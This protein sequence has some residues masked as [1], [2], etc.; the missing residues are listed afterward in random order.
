MSTRWR[1]SPFIQLCFALHAVALVALVLAPTYWLAVLIFLLLLHGV[2]ATVGLWP[3]SDWLGANIRR[4]PAA[5]AARGAIAITIDDGPDPEVT[6]QVLEI[7]RERGA[8]ATFFC[9]GERAQAHPALCRAIVSAGCAVENHGQRH[10]KHTATFGPRGWRDEVAQAQATLEVICGQRPRFFR[11][12]AGLR[13]PL[14]DPLLQRLGLQLVSWT[15]RGY[16]TRRLNPDRVLA[17]LLRDLAPGD[18]LLLHD[19]NAARAAGRPLILDVL[20]RLLDALAARNLTT[21]TLR[22]VLP[23]AAPNADATA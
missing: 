3:R 9:I 21:V 4:L 23:A 5:V 8:N 2:I 6:P 13:N 11:P 18:I 1:P 15:R 16:D 20:P 10:R 17:R 12:I 22:E 7:L 19:G 14:L